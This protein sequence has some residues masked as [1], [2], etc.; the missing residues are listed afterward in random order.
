MT[1]FHVYLICQVVSIENYKQTCGAFDRTASES[2]HIESKLISIC[3]VISVDNRILA[4]L[5]RF[6]CVCVCVFVTTKTIEIQAQTK[7]A[8]FNPNPAFKM[9]NNY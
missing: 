9:K 8:T 2:A 7:I 5:F 3:S 1:I 6:V 4:A